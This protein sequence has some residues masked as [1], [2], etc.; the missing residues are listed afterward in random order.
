MRK[1][2]LSLPLK[3]DSRHVPWRK[4]SL[5]LSMQPMTFMVDVEKTI[6]HILSHEDTDGDKRITILDRGPKTIFLKTSNSEGYSTHAVTGTYAVS[7]LLQE[8]ALA[9]ELGISTLALNKEM[10][11]ENPVDRLSR[12]IKHLYW[13]NLAR[14]V[15][16]DG[17]VTIAKDPK[18]SGKTPNIYIPHDDEMAWQY[19]QA[20]TS[21]SSSFSVKV[22]SF[23][24]PFE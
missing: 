10:L 9:Q 16:F 14:T 3:D 15:D 22:L 24:F 8:L 18:A 11:K 13:K 19:F 12:L 17:L 20:I 1:R 5:G 7:L 23:F 21:Q 2:S 4:Q 6:N